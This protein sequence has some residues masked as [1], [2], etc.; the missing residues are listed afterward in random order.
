MMSNVIDFPKT[1]TRNRRHRAT[2]SGA[3]TL[4]IHIRHTTLIA[5]MTGRASTAAHRDERVGKT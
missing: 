5:H 2:R 4:F 1:Q 3:K